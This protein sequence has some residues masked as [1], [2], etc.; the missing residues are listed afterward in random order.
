MASPGSWTWYDYALKKVN[1]GTINLN[2]DTLHLVL[3]TSS[4]SITRSF[5]GTSTN[6]QYSDLTAELATANGYTVGGVALTSS[7]LTRS[8]SNIVKFS[9]D[10]PT[11]TL[12]GTIIFKYAHLVDWTSTNKDLIAFCDLDVGGGSI[13]VAASPPNLA[14]VPDTALGFIYWKQ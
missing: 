14:F 5:V 2:S 6:A 4:Q 9:S 10:N 1:D 7:G 3:T 13:S 11:F 8:S 12:T